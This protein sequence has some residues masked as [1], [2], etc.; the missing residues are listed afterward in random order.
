MVLKD[1]VI[2]VSADA[3]PDPTTKVREL[4]A[5]SIPLWMVGFHEPRRPLKS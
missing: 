2:Q 4:A 3:Y 5:W 1:L